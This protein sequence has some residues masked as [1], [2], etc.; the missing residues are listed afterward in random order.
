MADA[1]NRRGFLR[2]LM[3]SGARGAHEVVTTVSPA[4]VRQLFDEPAEPA[5][6]VV[7]GA[8]ATPSADP[9]PVEARRPFRAVPSQELAQHVASESLASHQAAVLSLARRSVR[10]TPSPPDEADA[11]LGGTVPEPSAAPHWAGE[12]L[13]LIAQID[14]ASPVVADLPLAGAGWLLLFFDTRR[15]PS[16]LDAGCLGAWSAQLAEPD[17]RRLAGARPHRLDEELVLPRV[18]SQPVQALGLSA[19]QSAGYVRTRDWLAEAQ[20]VEVEQGAGSELAYHRLFGYPNETSGGMP[21]VCAAI[22]RGLE[23]DDPAATTDEILR[24]AQAW[25]LLAQVTIGRRRVFFWIEESDVR[26]SNL[27]R[28]WAFAA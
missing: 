3:R 28:V 26:S 17:E 22:A 23:P 1:S 5:D 24:E 9:E 14:L 2:E 21:R 19:E 7:T 10:L 25:H 27:D 18:W 6:T 13:E 20:G 15:W 8:D 4:A 11:W 16:G 12:R